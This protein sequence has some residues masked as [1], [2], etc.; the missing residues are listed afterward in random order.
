MLEQGVQQRKSRKLDKL[1]EDSFGFFISRRL[2]LSHLVAKVLSIIQSKRKYSCTPKQ[3]S[4]F[5]TKQSHTLHFLQRTSHRTKTQRQTKVGRQCP[6]IVILSSSSRLFVAAPC[7]NFIAVQSNTFCSV[8]KQ[9]PFS[10]SPRF[11]CFSPM[12]TLIP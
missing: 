4:M 12:A 8:S 5:S 7:R 3:R 11:L 1:S 6:G 9:E 10:S 2:S